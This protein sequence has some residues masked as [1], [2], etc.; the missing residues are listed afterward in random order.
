MFCAFWLLFWYDR[1]LA[2]LFLPAIFRF[3]LVRIVCFPWLV[4]LDSGL[5]QS[6]YDGK[7]N[8]IES[9]L[10]TTSTSILIFAYVCVFTHDYGY[11][12]VRQISLDKLT[13]I[14]MLWL[15]RDSNGDFLGS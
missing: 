8:R 2:R 7:V 6:D 1:L 14:A 4:L 15:R 12:T 10:S 13:A 11:D 5:Y 9:F 3:G